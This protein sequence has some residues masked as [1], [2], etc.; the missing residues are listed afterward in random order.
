MRHHGDTT[1]GE[2]AGADAQDLSRETLVADAVA[3][4]HALFDA[5]ERAP[6]T[7]L[8]GHSVGGAVAT[9]AASVAEGPFADA[10]EGLVVIDVVEGTALGAPLPAVLLLAVRAS[11]CRRRRTCDASQRAREAD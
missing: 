9:W 8:V 10:V 6:P 7:V 4:W 2:G 11:R 5:A 1:V 3:V